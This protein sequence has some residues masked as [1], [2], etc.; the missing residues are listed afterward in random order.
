MSYTAEEYAAGA[1]EAMI[2]GNEAL[3][4]KLS[5]LALEAGYEVNQ[6]P[7]REGSDWSPENF[8]SDFAAKGAEYVDNTRNFVASGGNSLNNAVDGVT[9]AVLTADQ[10]IQNAVGNSSV[11]HTDY[12]DRLNIEYESRNKAFNERVPDGIAKTAGGIAGEVVAAAPLMTIGGLAAGGGLLR[13]MGTAALEGGLYGGLATK[14]SLADRF[15]ATWQ[16]ALGGASIAG[17]MNVGGRAIRAQKLKNENQAIERADGRTSRGDQRVAEAEEQGFTL[18]RADAENTGVRD[19]VDP[20]RATIQRGYEIRE[21]DVG[22]AE[23]GGVQSWASAPGNADPN[24]VAYR[25][26]RSNQQIG[27]REGA[28]E[29]LPDKLKNRIDAPRLA[30]ESADDYVK[31]L[32]NMRDAEFKQVEDAY[33]AWRASSGSNV[34]LDTDGLWDLI[35][36]QVKGI[37]PGQKA[38]KQDI[39]DLLEARGIRRRVAGSDS[40]LDRV[41]TSLDDPLTGTMPRDTASDTIPI[42]E[43]EEI[44]QDINSLYK[45]GDKNWN[46]AS[47][48]IKQAVDDWATDGFGDISQLGPNHPVR[49]GKEARI[50]MNDAY[51]KWDESELLGKITKTNADGELA[52]TGSKSINEAIGANDPARIQKLRDEAMGDPVLT[53]ALED[54]FQLIKLDALERAVKNG[55][56]FNVNTFA[57][58]LSGKVYSR[59]TKVAMWGEEGANQVDAFIRSAK[60]VGQ[61]STQ[62][63]TVQKSGTAGSLMGLMG[64]VINLDGPIFRYLSTKG[65]GVGAVVSSARGMNAAGRQHEA[66]LRFSEDAARLLDDR[67]PKAAAERIKARLRQELIDENPLLAESNQVLS[68]I[69]TAAGRSYAA[70]DTGN[71]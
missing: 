71:P 3:A 25:A 12:L 31:R 67:L 19:Y 52:K 23:R 42:D 46:G 53:T 7:P 58:A 16:N 69:I 55:N 54:K 29:L 43:V 8:A 30:E 32:T 59:K 47:G 4:R 60:L 10:K 39:Y 65:G 35:D 1:K 49:L 51:T 17:G 63:G 24:A 5:K 38:L 18:D 66:A 48:K 64:K 37:R 21:S 41:G 15:A 20:G 50:R 22:L 9:E 45:Q 44:I 13:T 28:E 56:S 70:E 57:D 14:G 11:D 61:E 33:T 40:P 6:E 27:M 2:Q 62:K 34:R 36:E 68:Y 26:S